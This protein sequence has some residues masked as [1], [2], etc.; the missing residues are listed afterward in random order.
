MTLAVSY[1]NDVPVY[2]LTAGKSAPQFLE[3][4]AKTNKSLRY[5]SEFRN[6]VELLQDFEFPICSSRVKASRDGRYVCATGGYPWEMR[7]YDTEDLGMKFCRRVD[8]EIVDFTFLSDDYRKLAF[9]QSDRTIEFHAQYGLHHKLRVPKFSRCLSYHPESCVLFAAGSTE[10]VF[11]LDLEQGTFLTPLQSSKLESVNQTS[12]SG[13]MPLLA[14]GGQSSS[15]EGHCESGNGIVEF[16]DL[17]EAG[18]SVSHLGSGEVVTAVAFS[19]SGMHFCYGD[20]AGRVSVF[21]I[22]SKKPLCVRDHKNELPIKAVKYF[23][24]PGSASGGGGSGGADHLGLA[25]RSTSSTSCTTIASCDARSIKI[26]D[27]G[28]YSGEHPGDSSRVDSLRSTRLLAAVESDKAVLNDISFYPNSSLLL[29][30]VDDV[31]VGCYFLPS[32]GPAPAWCSFLDHMT[33]EL[34]E[35]GDKHMYEDHTFVSKEQVTELGAG[36]LIGTKYV[37]PYHHGFLMDVRTYERLKRILVE[38]GEGKSGVFEYEQKLEEK[39]KELM[40]EKRPMR[41]PDAAAR[42][43]EMK[44]K[45]KANQALFDKLNEKVEA[46]GKELRRKKEL[47]AAK[48]SGEMGKKLLADDRFAKM[49]DNPDFEI[50][51][52]EIRN[53]DGVLPDRVRAGREKKRRRKG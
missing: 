3:E 30:A 48:N 37:L 15:S 50:E 32:L 6:R 23:E 29:A 9:L 21:D 17:R 44:K 51:E 26:W 12:L 25:D 18:R 42:G 8:H 13:R 35:Q 36:D 38:E 31:R 43:G 45:V 10:E 5:N 49:F 41:V 53:A 2:N 4:A 34:A 27:Y 16:W 28:T 33:E 52:N 47:V 1:L 24:G 7:M 39:K 14:C 11:R 40:A 46:K 20:E 19:P 22:R